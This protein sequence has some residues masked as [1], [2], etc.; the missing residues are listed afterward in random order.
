MK[1]ECPH[2]HTLFRLT[3]EQLDMASGQV[4][5]G[6]CNEVFNALQTDDFGKNDRQL[7]VF[8]H[9][10]LAEHEKHEENVVHQANEHNRANTTI[11][12]VQ[13]ESEAN[14][15]SQKDETIGLLSDE[16]DEVVPDEF[17]A[18][19]PD[20]HSTLSTLL[21]SAAILLMI[22]GLVAEYAWFNRDL[23]LN[24]HQLQPY[25]ATLCEH[26]RC[27]GYISL[28]DPDSIEMLNRNVY[29]HPNEKN[30]L[31]ITATMI[32]HADFVQTLPDVQIDFSSTRGEV[33]ASRRFKPA[34]YI[35]PDH[36]GLHPMLPGLPVSFSLEIV[37]PGKDAI[38]YE[39]MF[40]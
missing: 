27:N 9:T 11:P 5:C 4:R 19:A 6:Y 7:D 16:P 39:F 33:V 3:E 23:L 20:R 38:T 34:E 37:D 31:M 15:S 24:Q 29:T 32:N 10:P 1:T 25:I 30:A 14:V 18:D 40:L 36:D 17:R 35:Q 28:R 2:C 21:W 12:P 8:E 26:I 22:A 13:T